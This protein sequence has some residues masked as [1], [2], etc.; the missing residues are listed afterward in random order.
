VSRE[1]DR[2]HEAENARYAAEERARWGGP[3]PWAGRDSR[4]DA[5]KAADAGQAERERALKVVKSAPQA[6]EWQRLITLAA[7]GQT[8]TDAAQNES[9]SLLFSRIGLWL[10]E[11]GLA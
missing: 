3:S 9:D 11:W 6:W 10:R 7:N 4:T 8:T 5:Q 2:Q 1:Y